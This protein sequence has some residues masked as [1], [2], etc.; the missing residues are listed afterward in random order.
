MAASHRRFSDMEDANKMVAIQA[1][2]HRVLSRWCKATG[3]KMGAAASLFIA[4]GIK[5]KTSK[6]SSQQ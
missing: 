4:E 1:K 2:V 6:R 5:Q 3:M